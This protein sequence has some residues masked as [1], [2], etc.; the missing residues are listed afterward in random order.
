MDKIII[1]A[2]H[3]GEHHKLITCIRTLF[4]E[5]EIQILSTPME[6]PG[7]I[8]VAPEASPEIKGGRN[9]KH[10]NYR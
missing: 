2:G 7:D 1:L 8:T 10:P 9:G 3:S 5:C 4:P 6:D